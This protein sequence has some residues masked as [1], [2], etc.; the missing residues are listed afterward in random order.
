MVSGG[1]GSKRRRRVEPTRL[2]A[3]GQEL[4]AHAVE[5]QTQ[6]WRPWTALHKKLHPSGQE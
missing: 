4:V 3:E 5:A 2:G 6:P 1:G